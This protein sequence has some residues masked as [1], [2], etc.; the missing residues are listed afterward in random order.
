MF[1]FVTALFFRATLLRALDLSPLYAQSNIYIRPL[2]SSDVGALTCRLA[3]T[4]RVT[5]FFN[6]LYLTVFCTVLDYG[7]EDCRSSLS[8]YLHGDN[9]ESHLTHFSD[10]Y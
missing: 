6:I 10:S 2:S 7:C 4:Y 9:L 3:A 5:R 1:V 8:A